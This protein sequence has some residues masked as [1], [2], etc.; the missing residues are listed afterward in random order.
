MRTEESYSFPLYHRIEQKARPIIASRYWIVLVL[1]VVVLLYLPILFSGFYQDDFDHRLRFSPEAYE[2][3]HQPKEAD[4][5]GPLTLYGFVRGSSR[6]YA[7]DKGFAPWWASDNIRA[8]FFRPLSS[9]TLAF[10]YSLWPDTP[11]LLH[12]HVCCGLAC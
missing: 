7:R 1:I 9:L 2:K 8:N 10:D 3:L 6:Q 12:I 5:R 11:L 4:Q